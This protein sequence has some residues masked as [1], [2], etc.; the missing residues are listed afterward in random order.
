MPAKDL[1]GQRFGRLVA[2]RAT[3]EIRSKQKIYECK[4]D[5]GN[6]SYVMSCNLSR[7]HT[8]SC[9]CAAR[10]WAV[11]MQK[12]GHIDGTN[13]SQLTKAVGKS[14]TSGTK[15][16]HYFKKC[17][18]WRARISFQGNRHSL[19]F[20]ETKQDAIKARQRAEEQYFHPFLEEYGGKPCT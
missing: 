9:G 4:C 10:D 14:N 3:G 18:L 8:Q 13:L 12:I 20:F 7:V 15:G 19:G 6:T 17:G 16:V 5:C 2:V 1:T 11:E